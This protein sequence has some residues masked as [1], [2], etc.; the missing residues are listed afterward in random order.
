VASRKTK[1]K[2]PRP[3]ARRKSTNGAPEFT[4]VV[5][6]LR[7]QFKVF[8]EALGG[9]RDQVSAGFE[10]VEHR[11]DGVEHRL[12]GVEHR[13]DGVEHRLDGVEHRLGVV[14]G[15]VAGLRHGMDLVKTV[16]VEH[17]RELKDIRGTLVRLEEKVDKKVDRE[18]V[19]ALVEQA[20][21]RARS[22]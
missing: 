20:V 22:G 5:E 4:V 15:D 14:E 8:G 19:E 2:V 11:L 18:E 12:D 17:S 9:L 1:A 16:L 3:A 6:D 21:A 7:S 10:R 13:L